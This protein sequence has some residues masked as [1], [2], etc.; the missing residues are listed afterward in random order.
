MHFG[1]LQ[2]L[3]NPW[4]IHEF[5]CPSDKFENSSVS[6]KVFDLVPPGGVIERRDSRVQSRVYA[7]VH[8]LT[9]V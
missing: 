8:L 3:L 7:Y 5:A 4:L 1:G 2:V 9:T 6:S